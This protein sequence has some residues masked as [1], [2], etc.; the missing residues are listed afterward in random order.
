MKFH[1]FKTAKKEI[2]FGVFFYFFN[3]P[4]PKFII[5]RL[6]ITY[7]NRLRNLDDA[8]SADTIRTICLLEE[9]KLID[10]LPSEGKTVNYN[11]EATTSKDLTNINPNITL[12]TDVD[13]V[14]VDGK[15]NINVEDF[16][17]VN[18]N[19]NSSSEAM[20]LQDNDIEIDDKISIGYLTKGEIDIAEKNILRIKGKEKTDIGVPL[21]DG[22]EILMILKTSN[23]RGE[24]KPEQYN[25]KV[26][27]STDD[28]IFDCDVKSKSINTSNSDLHLSVSNDTSQIITLQM[29]NYT[30]TSL[31]IISSSNNIKYMK[32]SSG[33]SGAAIAGIVIA[34][35]VVL[36]AASIAAIMLKKPNEPLENTTIVGLKTIE[37]S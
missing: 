13:M 35:V 32:N 30:D 31:Y 36:V 7:S 8:D 27:K 17:K 22:Q 10:K 3:K 15:G 21:T 34:C 4:I 28:L 29:L 12:N 9:P 25:C 33:L 6:R 26:N 2:K 20:N 11:C 14:T 19:A 18:F 5:F 1:N 24:K 37:I 23:R 16:S